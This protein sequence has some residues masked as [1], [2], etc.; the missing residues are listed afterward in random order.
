LQ[1]RFGDL[2]NTNTGLIQGGNGNTNSPGGTG[3]VLSGSTLSNAGTISAGVGGNGTADA[4]ILYGFSNTLIVDPGA[5][6]NGQVAV[7]N[8]YGTQTLDLGGTTPGTL[9]GLGTQ[10]TGFTNVATETGSN[11]ALTGA[12]TLAVGTSLAVDGKLS[13]N[14][15]LDSLGATSVAASGELRAG[16]NGVVLVSELALAGGTLAVG[17]TAEIVVGAGTA[18]TTRG[19]VTVASGYGLYGYGA[20][21]GVVAATQVID[22]GTITAAGGTL[23]VSRAISG[24]G[25]LAIDSGAAVVANGAVTV[26]DATFDGAGSLKLADP[27][28]FTSTIAGFSTGDTIDLEHLKVKSVSFSNDTLT[29]LGKAHAVLGTLLFTG[30]YTAANFGLSAVVG[31]TELS[32]IP[33]SAADFAPSLGA[34]A[35]T[36]ASPMLLESG[37][38]AQDPLGHMPDLLTLHHFGS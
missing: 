3:V 17:A 16:G 6:F 1:L 12:N 31:G 28:A 36:P 20:I 35:S 13:V 34:E 22:N 10:F 26:A 27:T 33:P 30:D 14:G 37:W 18:D 24:T 8:N 29:L 7:V 15:T 25:T 32:F 23:T 2:T 21:G 9:T 5:V 4:V 11:W 38:H 19:A